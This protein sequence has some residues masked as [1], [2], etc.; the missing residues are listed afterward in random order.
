[1]FRNTERDLRRR[2]NAQENDT[3]K[4][5]TYL[6]LTVHTGVLLKEPLLLLVIAARSIGF[7]R[8][9]RGAAP[10]QESLF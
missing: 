10:V 4:G 2:F 1:M 9:R 7:A 5:W 8:M 6:L 3:R